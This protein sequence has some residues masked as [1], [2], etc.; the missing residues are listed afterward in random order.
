MSELLPEPEPEDKADRKLL[1]D[2]KKYGHHVVIIPASQGT[3]G[4]AFSIGLYRTR[5]TPEIVVFGLAQE[6]AHFVVNELGRRSSSGPLEADQVHSGLI[7]DHPCILKP[8]DPVWYRSFLGYA[9]WY[10]RH[11]PFPVLQCI[12]VQRQLDLPGSDN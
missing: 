8:V 5:H 10:Y 2:V 6:V 7:E 4:W 1:A 3:P 9:G 11:R 12:C